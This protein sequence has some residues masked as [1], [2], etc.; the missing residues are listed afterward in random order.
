VCG[1]IAGSGSSKG[2]LAFDGGVGTK[3][4]YCM[5]DCDGPAGGFDFG[6]GTGGVFFNCANGSS[7]DSSEFC[8]ESLPSAAGD[9]RR[10]AAGSSSGPS[11]LRR[12]EGAFVVAGKGEVAPYKLRL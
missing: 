1:A 8:S 4:P 11:N 2:N 5:A 9:A 10:G 12:V 7:D 3:L 6:I